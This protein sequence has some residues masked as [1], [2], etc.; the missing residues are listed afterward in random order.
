MSKT[1]IRF[2]GTAADNASDARDNLWIPWLTTANTFTEDNV[3]EQ[4]IQVDWL[5]NTGV[6]WFTNLTL[7]NWW[8]DLSWYWTA[9]YYKD[10]TW[11]IEVRATIVP[12]GATSFATLPVWYRPSKLLIFDVRTNSWTHRINVWTNWIMYFDTGYGSYAWL[13][14]NFS[15]S[16]R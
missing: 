14:A 11:R 8:T 15:F 16:I 9:D 5:V 12:W 2:W 1:P 6:P 7:V 10:A 4:D 3:F 13:A